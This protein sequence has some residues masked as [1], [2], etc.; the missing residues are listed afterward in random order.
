MNLSGILAIGGK[1]GLFKMISSTKTGLIVEG[2]E[3]KK[4]SPV[5]SAHQISALEEISIY[6]YEEDVPLAEVFEKIHTHLNG[7]E[8]ISPKSSK[9][10]LMAFFKEVLPFY[11]EEEVYASDVK[12]IVQWYKILNKLDMLVFEEVKEEEVAEE[13]IKEEKTDN[14]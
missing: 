1:G 5:Y 7:A 11:N 8:I 6:T 9:N 4:R 12:K 2:L 13:E 3:D 14:K 10:D